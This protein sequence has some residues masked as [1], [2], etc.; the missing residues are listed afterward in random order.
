[1]VFTSSATDIIQD[2]LNQMVFGTI[3]EVTSEE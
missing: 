1:M 2:A 3:E